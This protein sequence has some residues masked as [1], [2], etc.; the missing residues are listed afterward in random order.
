MIKLLYL[1]IYL[2]I[3]NYLCKV[4]WT[5]GQ[6]FL[7]ILPFAFIPYLASL[8]YLATHPFPPLLPS[9]FNSIGNSRD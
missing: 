3:I 9:F 6:G 8:I 1:V 2:F 5:V 7:S 4:E